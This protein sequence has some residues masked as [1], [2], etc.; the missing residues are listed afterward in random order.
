MPVYR[1]RI[2]TRSTAPD[3]AAA[4]IVG[5]SAYVWPEDG[6]N[7]AASGRPPGGAMRPPPYRPRAEPPRYIVPIL[8]PVITIGRV[9][10]APAVSGSDTAPCR[11]GAGPIS[12]DHELKKVNESFRYA[13]TAAT[14]ST[15]P[16]AIRAIRAPT[17][18]MRWPASLGHRQVVPVIALAA[19]MMVSQR[20]RPLVSPTPSVPLC[21][22]PA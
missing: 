11:A 17:C 3:L 19:S 2:V 20:N 14:I 1:P 10:A 6:G 9:L 15:W 22:A 18:P 7:P 13:M 21:K 5:V 16:M 12:A 8:L 4:L